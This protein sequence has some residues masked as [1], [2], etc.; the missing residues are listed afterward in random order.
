M[1]IPLMLHQVGTS[2][3]CA[4]LLQVNIPMALLLWSGASVSRWK[5]LFVCQRRR[6]CNRTILMYS[7]FQI[8]LTLCGKNV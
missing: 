4:L 5:L 8:E 7:L 1:I 2:L 3:V 6:S